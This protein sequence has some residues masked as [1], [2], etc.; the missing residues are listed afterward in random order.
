LRIGVIGA[1]NV[2]TAL[3]KRLKPH[4]HDFK[5]SFSRD[6]AKLRLAAD[7]FGVE[8][9]L[10]SEIVQWAGVVALTVPWG[11]VPEALDQA[12]NMPGK[13]L[14]DCTNALLPD[15]SGLAIG[16]T[17][18]GGETVARLAIGTKVVKGIPPMAELLHSDDPTVNGQ[19][20]GLF[21][22][23]PAVWVYNYFIGKIESFDV[24]MDNSSSELIDYF[25]KRS[26][27]RG[28]K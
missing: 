1:G 10:P 11:A 25:I 14:W 24:E 23:V 7:A 8:T 3:V 5:L 27:M 4:G 26:S 16:T 9:G 22:A 6:A 21:V 18:S 12:G 13:I 20:V 17:T 15:M 2:G 28:K 19:P